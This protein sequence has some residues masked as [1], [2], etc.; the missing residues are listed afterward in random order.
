MR[1]WA[2][3]PAKSESRRLPGKNLRRVGGETLVARAVTVARKAGCFERVIVSTDAGPIALEAAMAGAEVIER[4]EA[5]CLEQESGHVVAHWLAGVAVSEEPEAICLLLPTSPVRTVDHVLN[6]LGLMVG[7]PDVEI[8]MSVSP[9]QADIRYALAADERG[10]MQRALAEWRLPPGPY[11][12]HDGT[13]LW[14]RTGR[15]RTGAFYGPKVLPY[16]VAPEES[17]DVN[18]PADLSRAEALAARL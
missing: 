1:T 9:I 5:C 8:V 18:T 11:Y 7:R 10:L 14:L 13:A 3:I 6:A 17:C 16:Y 15:A 2:F 12:A 4:T